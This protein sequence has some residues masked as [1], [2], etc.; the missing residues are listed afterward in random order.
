MYFKSQMS[1]LRPQT[2][3]YRVYC[4]YLDRQAQAFVYIQISCSIWSGSTLFESS[5]AVLRH[6]IGT[7]T[8]YDKYG[9][10]FK[11]SNT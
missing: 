8:L 11:Y 2:I 10:E 4:K 1:N 6:I 9:K 7:I 5:F 3:K